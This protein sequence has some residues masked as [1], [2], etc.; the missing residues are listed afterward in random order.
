MPSHRQTDKVAIVALAYFYFFGHLPM[1]LMIKLW[2][3][4]I[5]LGTGK[6]N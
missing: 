6:F 4:M 2:P 1:K 3:D 5:E